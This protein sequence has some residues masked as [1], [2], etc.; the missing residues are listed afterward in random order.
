M[1]NIKYFA[2]IFLIIINSCSTSH[3]KIKGLTI[4]DDDGTFNFLV[5]GDWGRNGDFHQK[6]VAIQMD[7]TSK[8]ID[9]EFVIST[10]DNFYDAGVASINDP[11]WERSFEDI[12]TGG[13]M[14]KEWFVVLGNHDY[15]GNPQAQIDYTQKSRR[16]RM[17]ARY[18]TFSKKVDKETRARFIFLDTN[19]F[20]EKYQK[21]AEKYSDVAQQNPQKQLEWL[22]SVL[23]KSTEKYK[24]VVGHHPIFSTGES[25][26]DTPELIEKL[27]PMLEK[28]GV[29]AYFCGHDHD[30]QHQKP[31]DSGIEYFVSGAGS[32]V[33]KGVTMRPYTKFASA[34]QGFA[35]VSISKKGMLLQFIDY[36]GRVVYSFQK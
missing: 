34:I 1:K 26:G 32:E 4:G 16:W 31:E 24:I 17:P 30:L 35:A 14:V 6:D 11:I 19:P 13:G 29:T 3:P 18:F 20:V 8:L 28:H 10:G 25:H 15:K 22:D 27:K 5:V 33:R 7:K 36:K 2:I 21:E 12:Y 9:P 23:V